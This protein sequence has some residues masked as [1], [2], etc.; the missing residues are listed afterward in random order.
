MKYAALNPI[1]DELVR[2][3][4]IKLSEISVTLIS[5]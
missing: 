3:S 1:L 4:R 2:K 5:R